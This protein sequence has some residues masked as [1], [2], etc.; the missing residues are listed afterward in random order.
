MELLIVRHAIAVEHGDPAYKRDEDRP[1]TPEGMH[2]FRLAARG[3]KEFADAPD[4]IVSSPL[5]RARQTA[6]IL[7]DAIA[8]KLK[9]EYCEDLVPSGD[10]ARALQFLKGLGSEHVAIVGHEPHLSGFTSYLLVGE[11]SK[12]GVV[13]KKGGAALVTFPGTPGPGH[14]T[15]EW[16]VQ[17]AALRDIA[18]T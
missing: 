3:L 11:K 10:F 5:V 15:L 6:E 14:G 18:A 17:P 16:L 8:P 12:A 13:F 9:I 4:R 1:L 7:R 2:K